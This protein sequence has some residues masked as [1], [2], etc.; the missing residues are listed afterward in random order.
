MCASHKGPSPKVFQ[1]IH[2]WGISTNARELYLGGSQFSKSKFT[3]VGRI[4]NPL[5]SLFPYSAIF[6][7]HF[8]TITFFSHHDGHHVHYQGSNLPPPPLLIIL[9]NHLLP[10]HH[11]NPSLSYKFTSQTIHRSKRGNRRF[12]SPLS[13]TRKNS[14]A[15]WRVG[16]DICYQCE[17]A[18]GFQD[19]D[20]WCWWE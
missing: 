12:R 11:P 4:K 2:L 10:P 14:G 16:R 8:F 9:T 7:R 1:G 13:R 20:S 19:K 5:H 15:T 18:G 17:T 6:I 3:P